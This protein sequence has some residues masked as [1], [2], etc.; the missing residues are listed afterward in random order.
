M[1]HPTRGF[2]QWGCLIAGTV[3]V[4]LT[5]QAA[6]SEPATPPSKAKAPAPVFVDVPDDKR[7]PRVL[8]IGD[9][10]SMGMRT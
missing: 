8:L 10:I 3:L 1:N 4:F 5:A 7:L 2:I 9:S 6:D